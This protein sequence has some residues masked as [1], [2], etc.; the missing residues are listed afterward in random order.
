MVLVTLAY[1]PKGTGLGA[2][3][4]AQPRGCL[5]MSIIERSCYGRVSEMHLP[6]WMFIEATRTE[7]M[8]T[9]LE[10]SRLEKLVWEC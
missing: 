3:L 7:D 6:G 1:I 2:R 4:P 8:T 10:F 9:C 5:E